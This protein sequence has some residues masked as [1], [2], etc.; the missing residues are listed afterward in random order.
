[1][2]LLLILLYFLVVIESFN[3][4]NNN[5]DNNNQVTG[6]SS[7]D[8]NY[9]IK[10]EDIVQ[11]IFSTITT[12]SPNSLILAS[13]DASRA[14][15]YCDYIGDYRERPTSDLVKTVIMTNDIRNKLKSGNIIIN[16]YKII[17]NCYI[18]Y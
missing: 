10:V 8:I 6:L 9:N 4:I 18:F 7:T 17:I 12:T 5:S 16:N 13:L 14:Q 3:F 2:I 11:E 15:F 1:M